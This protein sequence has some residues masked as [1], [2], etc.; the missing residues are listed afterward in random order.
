MFVGRWWPCTVKNVDCSLVQVYYDTIERCEWIY[1]G[2]TRLSPMFRE[3]QAATTR[4]PGLRTTR[5][6]GAVSN[7]PLLGARPV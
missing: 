1:R 2:S 4:H 7:P 3:E 6:L 5:K